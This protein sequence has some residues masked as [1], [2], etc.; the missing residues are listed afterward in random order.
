[1]TV[2]RL[3]LLDTHIWVWVVESDAKRMSKKAVELVNRAAEAEEVLVSDISFWEVANKA[4]REKLALS[5]ETVLWLERAAQGPGA[6]YIPVERAALIQST[7][8]IGTPPRDPADRI[9]IATAQMNS[10]TLVTADAKIIEY[11]R[12]THALSVYDARN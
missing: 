6:K 5:I 7:R 4:S 9:L 12:D 10:A 3:L 2:P 11:A 8:L 1:M